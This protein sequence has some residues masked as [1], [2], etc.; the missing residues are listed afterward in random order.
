MKLRTFEALRN[1]HVRGLYKHQDLRC[2]FKREKEPNFTN[3]NFPKHSCP[4][5]HTSLV[6]VKITFNWKIDNERLI[7]SFK[8]MS[9]SWRIR[10]CFPLVRYLCILYNSYSWGFPP[11]QRYTTSTHAHTF[12]HS[13]Q[14]FLDWCIIKCERRS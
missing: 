3:Y 1:I 2:I 9:V 14:F 4:S 11:I 12:T 8:Q 13:L 6:N 7:H 5:F 10:G